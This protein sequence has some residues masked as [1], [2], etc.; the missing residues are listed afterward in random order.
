MVDLQSVTV[1][2]PATTANIG[3][4]FDC[5]GAAL[6]LYN[7][8]SFTSPP[9]DQSS[10]V[11][12]R[13]TGLDADRV[14][15]GEQN[16]AY[17]SFLKVFSFL[18]REVPKVDLDIDLQVPLARGLGS[19]AT[20]IVG[21]L[22]GGNAIA[23]SPLSS[24]EL[25]SMAIAL[26][27]HPDNVVPALKGSCQLTTADASGGWQ[28][29][30]I[31]WNS[32]LVPV[33]AIPNFELSTAEARQALPQTYSRAD[34]IFNTAHMGLLIRA[35]ETG[36]PDWLQTAL[37]DRIHQPY[38]Q[39][40]IYGY[41]AV[42]ETALATGAHGVVISGAGPT[43]LALTS[44]THATAVKAAMISAWTQAGFKPQAHILAIDTVGAIATIH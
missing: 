39:P 38:R 15:T 10:R 42:R 13:V 31:P 33:V 28:V 21:G 7:T 29:C 44:S 2:V 6:A 14:S 9:S 35:I 37:Q 32:A 36:N 5:L 27:G 23:G 19:S 40:L 12:I 18:E 41:D 34:A 8:F 25:M 26:E 22:L 1:R 43:I 4:G 3:P 24:A 16:L 30:E 20:A 17:Q 11:N